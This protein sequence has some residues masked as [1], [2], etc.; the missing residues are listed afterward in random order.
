MVDPDAIVIGS[1]LAGLTAALNILDRGT[2]RGEG[3]RC[4]GYVLEMNPN[5]IR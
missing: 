2:S 5:L 3:V 4:T 1:G